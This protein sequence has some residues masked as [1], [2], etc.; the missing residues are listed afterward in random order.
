M[1]G[2]I[3]KYR[4]F[5]K[6]AT[7]LMLFV[8]C[9][10]SFAADS[11]TCLCKGKQETK[12]EMKCCS[13]KK[14]KNCCSSGNKCESHKTENSKDCNKCLIKKS[15]IQNPLSVNDSKLVK[16]DKVSLTDETL[17]INP[18]LKGLITFNTWRPPDKTSKIYISLSNFRI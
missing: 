5:S 2:V 3:S 16:T 15:D 13:M 6:T 7:L 10:T 8:F 1:K 12:K 11:Y 4:R 14:E 17:T 18:D 9:F